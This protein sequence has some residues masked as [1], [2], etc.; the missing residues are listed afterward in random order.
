MT[1]C[2]FDT[3]QTE[4][5]TVANYPDNLPVIYS[6]LALAGEAGEVANKVKKIYR[7]DGGLVTDDRRAQIKK[8]LGD[9]LWYVAALCSDLGLK[10]RDVA[11]G[12]INMLIDRK[13]RNV[14][15]GDGDDR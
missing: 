11:V 7:D 9:V 13:Q 8:E 5:R 2:T 6:A 4:A 14:L 10:M 12:N 1:F 3:Y 15:H